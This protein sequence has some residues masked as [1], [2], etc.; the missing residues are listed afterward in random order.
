MPTS[1]I[2][3]VPTLLGLAGIDLEQA[4]AGV[5]AHHVEV[6]ALPGRDLSDVLSGKASA[7]SVAA[8]VYFM[9]ED[10]PTKG[11]T[12]VNIITGVPFD[13]IGQASNI[14]SVITTLPTGPGQTEELWKLNHYYER[15][16]DWY[17]D[18]GFSKNPYLAP[19]ADPIFELHNLTADPEERHNLAG[20]RQEVLSQLRTQLG[21]QRDAK[22]LVPA[23]RN[24]LA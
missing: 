6:Q 14:E 21:A 1:H 9:T 11:S 7:D 13:A 18:K 19:P 15:L 20:A 22:R 8:P 5:S 3:L 12:Q 16:D 17:E 10:N 4:T 24:P 2:D 23:Q